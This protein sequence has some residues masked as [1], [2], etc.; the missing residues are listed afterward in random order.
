[1]K[2]YDIGTENAIHLQLDGEFLIPN[3]ELAFRAAATNTWATTCKVNSWKEL[4]V[5]NW[6]SACLG[7]EI[8]AGQFVTLVVNAAAD[9]FEIYPVAIP[10]N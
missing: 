2:I 1:M 4:P 9:G 8:I 6:W 7:W 10:W 3:T 5:T